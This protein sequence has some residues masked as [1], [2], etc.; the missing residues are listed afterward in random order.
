[1]RKYITTIGFIL[2]ALTGLIFLSSCGGMKKLKDE[3]SLENQQKSL[4]LKKTEMLISTQDNRLF[5]EKFQE[6]KSVST[7]IHSDSTIVF[8][9]SEGFKI[10]GGTIQVQ[11]IDNADIS[12]TRSMER[13][14]TQ[15]RDASLTHLS[16]IEKNEKKHIVEKER[17]GH[18]LSL[19]IPIA[20]GLFAIAF[21]YKTMNARR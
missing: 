15:R 20:A 16:E 8:N 18:E 2:A 1:M 4:E 17:E 6:H 11:Q 14:K 5:K 12:R 19:L 7:Y 13:S 3:T 21:W 10:K 9:P